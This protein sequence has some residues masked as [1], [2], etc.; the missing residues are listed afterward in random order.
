MA[1]V[2]NLKKTINEL[3]FELV[4]E[5]LSY[6]Y[7]HPEKDSGKTNKAIEN[8]IVMRNDLINKANHPTTRDD[9]KKNKS[10]FKGL[11]KDLRAMVS[12]M[13]NLA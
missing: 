10:Y 1:S 8:I 6:K 12:H 2:R 13:D 11:I 9:Y 3:T 7:F 5:C 4:S